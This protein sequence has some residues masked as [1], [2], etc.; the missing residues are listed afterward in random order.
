MSHDSMPLGRETT[1]PQ[2][3]DPGQ[4]YAVTRQENRQ[5]LGLTDGWPWFGVDV[6]N[7]WELSWLRPD[8]VPRVA[9]ARFEVPASSPFLVESKSLKLYLNSLN[10]TSFTDAAEVAVT[11]EKDLSAAV[12]APVG[13][14]LRNVDENEGCAARPLIS[15]LIDEEPFDGSREPALRIAQGP[16]VSESLCSHLLRSCCPVTGQP[17]WASVL[18]KYRG[19]PLDRSALLGY[20]VGFRSRQ[21]FHEHCVERIFS[22]IMQLC[23]PR[24]LTV[25]GWYTR[26][27]GIDINPWR[28]TGDELPPRVRLRRQ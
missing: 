25:G 20:L 24:S 22:D 14:E 3:Y 12:G 15:D 23:R 2:R 13:V 7:A 5:R 21:D 17:D 8:G 1:Y 27:G 18:I 26:R 4:L 11:L 6:W 9:T 19:A 10:G 16:E 28:T